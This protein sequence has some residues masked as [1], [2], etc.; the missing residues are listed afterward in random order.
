MQWLF[1]RRVR[2]ALFALW[3]IA[4]LITVALLL[5]PLSNPINLSH[6]DLIAHF[7]VFGCLAFGAVGFSRRATDLTLSGLAT[8][9]GGVTLEFAQGLV[10]YRTFDILDMGAN[11]LGA[12]VGYGGALAIL[13]L[14]IGPAADARARGPAGA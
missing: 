14:V 7:L 8:V 3:C 1:D 6:S 12:M 10:P 13:L 4:W 5:A 9:A 11:T 2:R